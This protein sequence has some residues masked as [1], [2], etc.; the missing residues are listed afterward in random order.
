[1]RAP[2]PCLTLPRTDDL[3]DLRSQCR[4]QLAYGRLISRVDMHRRLEFACIGRVTLHDADA[5]FA[6]RLERHKVAQ[7]NLPA[8]RMRWPP[9]DAHKPHVGEDENRAGGHGR[10]LGEATS[11]P[12]SSGCPREPSRGVCRVHVEFDDLLAGSVCVC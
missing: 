6:G 9:I 12:R 10:Q 7:K 8:E 3:L 1:M 11:C 2:E 4:E 5:M